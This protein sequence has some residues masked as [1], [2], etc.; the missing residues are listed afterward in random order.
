[1]ARYNVYTETLDGEF[2]LIGRVQSKVNQ[3]PLAYKKAKAWF[4]N[5]KN[6]EMVCDEP[7]VF[8][9]RHTITGEEDALLDVMSYQDIRLD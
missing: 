6:A 2:F 5:P 4:D 7:W 8:M 9:T 1:M 3:M